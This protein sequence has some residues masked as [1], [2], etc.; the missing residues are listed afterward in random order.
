[1]HRPLA[2]HC[3]SS[4]PTPTVEIIYGDHLKASWRVDLMTDLNLGSS[5]LP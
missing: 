1:M 2:S 4:K 5:L 3:R